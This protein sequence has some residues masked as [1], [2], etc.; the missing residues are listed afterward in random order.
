[1]TFSVAARNT[2]VDA[3]GAIARWISLHTADPGATGASEVAGSTRAQTTFPAAV[4]GTATGTPAG[5]QVPAGGPYT[6]WGAWSA[7]T[8]GT[9]YE[10]GTL[11][12]P[13]TYGSPGTYNATPTLNAT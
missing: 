13:E 6:H 3:I 8:G 1:M 2:A 7:Q 5:V 4:N 10:G 11:P 12:T 9:F